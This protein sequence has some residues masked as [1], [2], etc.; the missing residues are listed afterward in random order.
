MIKTAMIKAL[1][2]IVFQILA[3]EQLKKWAVEALDML[4]ELAQKSDN[5]IDD[6]IVVPLIAIIKGAFALETETTTEA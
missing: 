1:V 6:T 5:S 3:S 4:A 2:G